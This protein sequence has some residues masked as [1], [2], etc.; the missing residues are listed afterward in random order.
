M[1]VY[2]NVIKLNYLTACSMIK[3]VDAGWYGVV[4]GFNVQGKKKC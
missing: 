3:Y 4:E 1:T 2:K